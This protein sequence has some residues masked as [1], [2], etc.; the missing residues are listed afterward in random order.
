MAQKPLLDMQ[1]EDKGTHLNRVL[2]TKQRIPQRTYKGPRGLVRCLVMRKLE[3]RIFSS[4]NDEH[5]G[6]VS[7][8]EAYDTFEYALRLA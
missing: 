1:S 2:R 6:R 4:R 7:A 8:S 5:V 3:G